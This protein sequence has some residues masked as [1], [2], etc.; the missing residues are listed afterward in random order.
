MA[1]ALKG[2]EKALYQRKHKR[3]Y[4]YNCLFLKNKRIHKNIH[5]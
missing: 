1:L 3:T 5:I 2:F 4:H